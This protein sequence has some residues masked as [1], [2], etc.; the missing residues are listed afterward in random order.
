L[1]RREITL[2]CLAPPTN[3]ATAISIDPLLPG[4]LAGLYFMGGALDCDEHVEGT[5]ASGMRCDSP[6]RP[7]HEFNFAFD[8]EATLKLLRA[9]P[10]FPGPPPAAPVNF[11]TLTMIPADLASRFMWTQTLKSQITQLR[12]SSP[13]AEYVYR[14]L[15]NGSP[16]PPTGS[17]PMFDEFAA[18]AFLFPHTL[19]ATAA[20][21]LFVSV[22]AEQAS[23]A[24]GDTLWWEQG[25]QPKQRGAQ[26]VTV[27]RRADT[28]MFYRLILQLLAGNYSFPTATRPVIR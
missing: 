25:Q 20:Q 13:A 22:E 8:P 17:Y 3:I 12:A 26:L 28:E 27:H 16:P 5:E 4:R 14:Y 6:G 11:P 18:V 10:D 19:N 1:H 23:A 7:K 21:H 9:F 2:L 24:R 15:I